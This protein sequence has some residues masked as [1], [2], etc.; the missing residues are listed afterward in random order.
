M[1]IEM[2]TLHLAEHI[3]AVPQCIGCDREE[4]LAG[5][6]MYDSAHVQHSRLGGCA[7]RTHNCMLKDT[8]TFKLNPLKASK[9]SQKGVK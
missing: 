4:Y 6:E 8:N 1:T 5:C 7:G 2:I 9:R 3:G